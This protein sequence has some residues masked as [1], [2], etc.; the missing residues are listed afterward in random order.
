MF[1]KVKVYKKH[2]DQ[3]LN[4]ASHTSLPHKL[5]VIRKLYDRCDNMITEELERQEEIRHIDTVLPHFGYLQWSFKGVRS[6]DTRLMK[7]EKM[8]KKES[9]EKSDGEKIMVTV[10]FAKGIS[11]TVK[12]TLRRH[13][14]TTVLRPHKTLSGLLVHPKDKRE[15]KD[16][17]GVMYSIPY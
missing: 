4:F 2:S 10:P 9:R 6:M 17:T 7:A 14:I 1:F 8:K 5:H 16:T 11:G 12:C 3:Y 15:A 13:G